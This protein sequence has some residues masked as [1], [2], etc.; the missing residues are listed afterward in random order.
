MNAVPANTTDAS[1]FIDEGSRKIVAPMNARVMQYRSDPDDRVILFCDFLELD[2]TGQLPTALHDGAKCV[3]A[4]A[5]S[6]AKRLLT[7]R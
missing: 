6:R 1:D 7:S 4:L 5:R 2:N 3:L